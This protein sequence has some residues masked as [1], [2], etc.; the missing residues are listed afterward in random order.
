[1][2]T[3][4]AFPKTGRPP[5][6]ELE[7]KV[8]GGALDLGLTLSDF[9]ALGLTAE[10]LQ[11]ELHRKA[12]AIARAKAERHLPVTAD[13]VGSAGFKRQWFTAEQVEELNGLAARSTLTRESL[14][15][16]ADDLR[17]LVRA[18]ALA[19]ALEEQVRHLRSGEFNLGSVS[20]RLEALASEINRDVAP[21]EDAAGDVMGVQD[22]WDNA[23]A[24]GKSRLLP[25]CISVLDAQI[26]GLP[27]GLTVFGAAPGVGKTAVLD[28]MIRA[29]LEADPDLHLGFFGLEDGTDHVIR[30][31]V[32]A[33]TGIPL[34]E[35]GWGKRTAEQK[36]ACDEAFARAYP[37][38]KRLHVYRRDTI[39]PDQLLL[40]AAR[41]RAKFGVR[42][43][44]VD[45]LTE[46]DVSTR[47]G[48]QKEFE[49]IGELGRRLRNFALREQIPVA[50]IAHT[51]GAL[52]MGEIPTIFDLAGGQALARRVRLFFGLWVKGDE[53]RCT[54]GKANE[55]G[56]AGVT[57]A[58]ERI[59][60]AGLISP[61]AGSKVNLQQ[62]K[63]IERREK[64]DLKLVEQIEAA[65]RRREL[66]KK[67][68]EPK[69]AARVESEPQASLFGGDDDDR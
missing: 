49:A 2:S 23:E 31:W 59:V 40:R 17:Q 36:A 69:P 50:L 27:P 25:T 33:D 42:G 41:M 66:Q 16:V 68:E 14:A 21:D 26:G 48:N 9:E 10:D 60:T 39:R 67:L 6:A 20:G 19:R 11:L 15:S 54:T 18:A 24:A 44:Y 61:T 55:L 34:R 22:T 38:L 43:I 63:A 4:L 28:S 65:K 3:V 46:V 35:V 12:W 32:A 5:A 7:A 30:R 29:Q 45:N 62:E 52:R 47:G 1:M 56:P 8:V 57:V 53:L 58:F 37:L 13:T 64:N 51:V